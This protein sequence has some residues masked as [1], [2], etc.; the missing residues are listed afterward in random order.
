MRNRETSGFDFC[1][2][3]VHN[4]V[5]SSG[6]EPDAVDL[7]HVRF[8]EAR[9]VTVESLPGAAEE[10]LAGVDHGTP[11]VARDGAAS[12]RTRLGNLSQDAAQ[13]RMTA[14]RRCGSRS[15]REE[16]QLL[17]RSS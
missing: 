4:M 14:V 8:V 10:S 7:Q 9:Q 3:G 5:P 12:N 1:D 2:I 13:H 16:S 15:G 17:T 11:A 6:V